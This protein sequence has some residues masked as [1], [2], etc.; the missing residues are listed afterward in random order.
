MEWLALWGVNQAVG[1]VFKPILEELAK[2]AA[3]DYVKDFFKSCLSNILRLPQKEPIQIATG[4]AITEFLKLIQQELEDADLDDTTIRQYS[5]FLEEFIKNKQVAE[6]LGSA[7][8]T[9]SVD[10]R[11]LQQIW[12]QL[13]SKTLPDEF[14]WERVSK[15]YRKKVKAIIQEIPELREILDSQNLDKIAEAVV[16]QPDFDLNRHQEGIREKYGN[17]NLESLDTTG[18]AYNTLKLWNIFVPQNVRECQE[19]LPQVYEIPKEYFRQLKEQGEIDR[20]VSIEELEQRRSL[21]SQQS[22][23]SILEVVNNPNYK[24]LVVLGDPG[25]GKSTLLQYL[26]LDWAKLSPEKLPN[27]YIPL[28][29]ELRTY[30]RD[31]QENKCKNILEF[32]HHGNVICHF[33]QQE[34]HSRLQQGNVLVLFDG[35]DEVF[36]PAQREEVITDIH[37]FTNN[38]PKVRAIVTSRVIGYK[39]QKLR[40]AEFRHFMLQ[41]LEEEQIEEFMQKWHELTFND[42]ADKI[43]KRDRLK[44]AIS[45]SSAIRELAGNPLLLTMM[46]ILNRNQELPRDRAELYN[47][48][49]RVLLHQWDIERALQD[50]KIDPLTI[51]YKDKQEMLRRV[52]FFMQDNEKGLAGNL[53]SRENLERILQDYLQDIVSNART[54]ARAVIE[55]LRSRNFILCDVGGDFYAFI[56]RTFLE[57]FCAW[58]FVWQFEKE[59]SLSEED[60]VKVYAEHWRDEAWHEVLRL[61][62]GMLDPKFIGK[63]LEYLMA[64]EGEADKFINLFLAAE[65]LLEV[66]NRS[67][68]AKIDNELFTRIES[69]I[70]YDIS[71]DSI[72]HEYMNIPNIRVLRNMT[73]AQKIE[74]IRTEALK[75]I[76]NT[77]KENPETLTWLKTCIMSND[78]K[79]VQCAA[80]EE[81][82]RGFKHYPDT[83]TWLKTQPMS[84][85][86]WKVRYA[87]IQELAR[88][89]KHY[90]ET[91]SILETCV[92]SDEHWFVRYIA[93]EELAQAYQDNPDTLTWLKTRATTDEDWRVRDAAVKVLADAYKD[94]PDTLTWLK[95]RATTDEDWR[96]RDAAVQ[97][98]VENFKDDSETLTILKTHATR[99]DNLRV[100]VTAVEALAQ[101]YKDDPELFELFCDRAINDPFEYSQAG[102]GFITNPRRT[103]LEAIIKNYPNHPKTLPFLRDRAINDPDEKLREWA[104]KQLEKFDNRGV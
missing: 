56:H 29:I 52:A 61:M 30:A 86:N 49:S 72:D 98:L 68:I 85:E 24:Y 92:H 22:I 32:F 41:D 50:K 84:H 63:V 3:K 80:L 15:R 77:W 103:A 17:L 46:A 91:V 20:D 23:Q 18:C 75:I 69:L 2:D 39:A 65:C 47:Q 59:R 7:F 25:S 93:V 58:Q 62:A 64:Q 53:I 88:G 96:V 66:R 104:H 37:R 4:K 44:Q 26:A 21:Y 57:Y 82:A 42:E 11:T 55:Q 79:N 43:R 74:E 10:T 8:I 101:H 54:I 102:L 28:L 60:L 76:A 100:R 94:N 87:T 78:N 71:Y 81:L 34:L 33:P 89:F 36:D 73:L 51:D 45:N 14:N 95:T 99:D 90:P 16:V 31:K 35:L 13:Q 5:Y 67:S 19:Y 83:L 6:I 38:Y 97:A 70:S 1:F 12:K 48:A 9:D 40:D 27:Y